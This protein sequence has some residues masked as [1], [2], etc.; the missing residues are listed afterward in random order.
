MDYSYVVSV[1]RECRFIIKATSVHH[2]FLI[3]LTK[4]LALQIV[5]MIHRFPQLRPHTLSRLWVNFSVSGI[6]NY[7]VKKTK[8]SADLIDTP[9]MPYTDLVPQP[10]KN[11]RCF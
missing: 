3:E 6:I 1:L 9:L 11:S 5:L 2:T 10:P 4:A 7:Y 8:Q